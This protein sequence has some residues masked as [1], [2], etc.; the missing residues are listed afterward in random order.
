[1]KH[2]LLHNIFLLASI[3][4]PVGM[5]AQT[6][7][8]VEIE[9]KMA[10][11]LP[12]SVG[13][14][15]PIGQAGLLAGIHNDVM[16]LAGGANFPDKVPWLGGKKRYYSDVFVFKKGRSGTISVMEKSFRLPFILPPTKNQ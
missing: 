11:T 14:D 9:W 4:I 6:K 12:A 10:A 3:V 1:M 5:I 8:S 16:I 7:N 13:N 15:K 2:F